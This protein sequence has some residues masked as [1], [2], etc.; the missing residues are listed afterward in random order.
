MRYVLGIDGGGTKTHCALYDADTGRLDMLPWGPTNHEGMAGGLDELPGVLREMFKAL[1]TRNNIGMNDI[2][3]GVLG[4]AGT[5]TTEQHRI[6]SGILTGLGLRRFVLCNDAY[7][8]VKAGSVGGYGVCAISGTGC[9]ITGIDAKGGQVQ[10]GGLGAYTGDCGGGSMMG[11]RAVGLVY[12]Q[13]FRE[14]PFT[15]LTT[16][17]FRWLDVTDKHDFID[18]LTDRLSKDHAKTTLELCRILYTT[19][20]EGDE[21]ALGLLEESGVSYAGGIAGAISDLSFASDEPI[22]IVFAGSLFTKCECDHVQKTAETLLRQRFPQKELRF[23]TLDV[24]NVAG[25]V[26]WAL[27]E[28]GITDRRDNVLRMFRSGVWL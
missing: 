20:A 8:G 3:M 1:L 26:L 22:E 7:L 9:C 24:P 21:T 12:S 4:L 15:A 11:P 18:L 27:S 16:A 5:D 28:L 6:I 2:E 25:A 13:L 19:A 17:I 10:V 14:Q 23:V